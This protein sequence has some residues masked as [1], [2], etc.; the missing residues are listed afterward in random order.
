[1]GNL[2]RHLGGHANITHLDESTLDYLI[3]KYNVKSMYD[4][5]CS[6]G[7]MVQLAQKKGV[8]STGID[9]DFTLKHPDEINV[10]LHDFTIGPLHLPEADLS[11]S[12]EFL[13]HVHEK[14]MDNY[15]AVFRQCKLICCTFSTSLKGHHHV[16]V[17]NQSYWDEKFKSYGFHKDVQATDCIRKKSSMKRDFIRNTGTIYISTI[18][19]IEIGEYE[20]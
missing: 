2:P 14:Y 16:N 17:K 20:N 15:F 12:V 4:V 7:G 9:G 6:V 1:M 5:G 18:M 19:K 3:D 11:W 13:E 10:I 8:Q